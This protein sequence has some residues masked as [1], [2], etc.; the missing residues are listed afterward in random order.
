MVTNKIRF[1]VIGAGAG[2]TSMAVQLKCMGYEVKLMDKKQEIVNTLNN[3]TTLKVSGKIECEG[4]PDLITSNI[5]DAIKAVDVIMIVTTTEAHSEIA[6]Q[7]SKEVDGRQIIVLTPGHVGGVLNF[8][9]ELVK[10]GC[11]DLPLIGET[12]DLP[13]AC[14]TVEVGHTLH[15]GI[16]KVIKLGTVP[17]RRAREIIARIGEA[18]PMLVPAKNILETGLNGTN[19]LLHT[20]PSIMN[21]N[22]I[23]RGESFD[24]YMEGITPRICKVIEAADKEICNIYSKM[25]VGNKGILETLQSVYNLEYD[26]LY[27]AIQ[28]NKPYE[29]LTPPKD[30]QHRFFQ[31]DSLSTLVPLVSIGKMIGV[32]VS[33]LESFVHIGS[34]LT[35][36]DFMAEGRTVTSLGLDGK[37][38]EEIYEMI[39]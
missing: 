39:S 13:Y 23:E 26:N 38:K 18:F 36:Q 8:K 14:R 19:A 4:K 29:G 32:D 35:G 37:T 33:I 30:V 31:E 11:V 2:G 22:K 27:D 20:I 16:K 3:K 24:Y 9:N 25:G 7:I 34:A 28:N 6:K 21:I 17:A 15:T 12:N 5:H 1:A 10:N